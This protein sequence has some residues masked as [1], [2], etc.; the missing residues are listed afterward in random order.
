M[1]KFT[2]LANLRRHQVP[3]SDLADLALRLATTPCS[4]LYGSN[5]SPDRELAAFLRTK[6]P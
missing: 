2:Q 3:R 5:V 4:P 1:N 6:P